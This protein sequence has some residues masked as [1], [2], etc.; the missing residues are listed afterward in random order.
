MATNWVAV[1]G[2]LSIAAGT[3]SVQA[4]WPPTTTVCKRAA[5]STTLTATVVSGVT[6]NTSAIGTATI[7]DN[8]SAPSFSSGQRPIGEGG[9]MTHC[10]HPHGRRIVQQMGEWNLNPLQAATA[11]R[12]PDFTQQH[13]H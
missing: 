12:P 3:T 11:L 2:N 6:S 4:A 9:L 1:T 8:D 10:Q 13:R 7:T 5:E